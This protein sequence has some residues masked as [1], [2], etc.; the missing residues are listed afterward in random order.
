MS[1]SDSMRAIVLTAYGSPEESLQF[2]TMPKP[3]PGAL[4]LL[5]K[6]H[7][8]GINPADY[9]VRAGYIGK[10]DLKE[11]RIIG[12]DAAG[13]VVEVG[14]EAASKFKVGDEVYYAGNLMKSGSYAQYQAI[15]HRLVA[16]KPK[17]LTFEQAA[18]LPLVF[19]TAWELL[20]EQFAIDRPV[21]RSYNTTKEPQRSLLVVAGAGGVGSISIQIGKL[22]GL[23]VIA[24]ASR[25]DS[26]EFA[27]AQGAD[28][29]IDHSKGI[30]EELKKNGIEQVDIIY[31]TAG[32]DTKQLV[33][34]VASFGGIGVIAG[35]T[36]IDLEVAG[37]L[38]LK[39]AR[40]QYEIMFA[41]SWGPDAQR[42]GDILAHLTQLVEQG[43]IQTTINPKL[44]RSW[45][46][47]V[48]AQKEI[49]S[50]KTIGKIVM[51]VDHN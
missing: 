15:D 37:A 1:S 50:G 24:T 35:P 19:L 14:S 45:D 43:K 26:A 32:A 7:A 25:P 2:K 27:K 46:Q 22:F 20:V 23:R 36:A 11:G 9:K 51:T 30:A 10:D 29:I 18:A 4:D 33:P 40:I 47:F 49:E 12:W 21:L 13:V 48:D 42:T 38:Y 31:N 3:K 28:L 5:V 39:A 17:S 34:I 41:R 16:H 6:I 8:I 44:T